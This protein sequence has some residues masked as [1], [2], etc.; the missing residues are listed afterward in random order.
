[1]QAALTMYLI[2]NFVFTIMYSKS[3]IAGT[4]TEVWIKLEIKS[5]LYGLYTISVIK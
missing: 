4:I 5:M 2:T 3:F 1:M